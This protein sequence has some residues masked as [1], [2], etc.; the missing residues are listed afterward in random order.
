MV[1]REKS[2]IFFN[3]ENDRERERMAGKSFFI[4]LNNI[5][6]YRLF[7]INYNIV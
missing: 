5:L 7:I 6:G 2:K 4:F 3:E 1:R